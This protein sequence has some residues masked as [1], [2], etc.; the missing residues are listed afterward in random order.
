MPLM[1]LQLLPR[2]EIKHPHPQITPPG[3]K[4]LPTR[5]KR[6]PSLLPKMNG[7]FIR[8]NLFPGSHIEKGDTLPRSHREYCFG[9]IRRESEEFHVAD[10][11]SDAK[12]S[13]ELLGCVGLVDIPEADGS[14]RSRG[15]DGAVVDPVAFGDGYDLT[16]RELTSFQG[17]G[18]GKYDT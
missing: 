13:C 2:L 3:D 16:R 10:A 14:V 7:H 6:R 5:M 11:V 4:L 1:T 12:G 15:E 18:C 17:D 8:M 9:R